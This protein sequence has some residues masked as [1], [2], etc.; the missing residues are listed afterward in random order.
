MMGF[1]TLW[2]CLAVVGFTLM[3]LWNL[4]KRATVN[5]VGVSWDSYEVEQLFQD[6]ESSRIREL[7]EWY[8]LGWTKGYEAGRD[9]AIAGEIDLTD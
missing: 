2:L 4:V 8:E 9:A 7:S 5:G 1:L 3:Y 6:E